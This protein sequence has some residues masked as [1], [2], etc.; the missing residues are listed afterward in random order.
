MPLPS[1]H[2]LPFLGGNPALPAG[3]SRPSGGEVRRLGS[4]ALVVRRLA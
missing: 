1:G 2:L 3:R 4:L